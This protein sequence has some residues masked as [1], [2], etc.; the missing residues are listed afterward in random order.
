LV[1][2]KGIDYSTSQAFLQT[3]RKHPRGNKR[4]RSAGHAWLVLSGPLTWT[5]CG[6]TGE[7][8]LDQPDYGDSIL[9]ALKR[10]DPNPVAC[11]WRDLQ[12]GRKEYGSGGHQPTAAVRFELTASQHEAIRDFI[13]AYD[14]R[15]FSV[16]DRVCTHFVSRAAAL[17]GVTLGHLVTLNIPQRTSFQGQTVTWWTDSKFSNISFGSPDV[18]EKSLQLAVKKG[19]G[20]DVLKQYRH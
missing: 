7:F 16:R 2:A 10:N 18:L 20:Q 1:D 11:L 9:A 19:L 14:Y 8:G 17:A 15:A 6:H 5:E 12:D 13:S 3:M 4:D